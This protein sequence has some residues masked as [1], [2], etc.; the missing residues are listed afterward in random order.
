MSITYKFSA[1]WDQ[2]GYY[3][4]EAHPGDPLNHVTTPLTWTDWAVTASAG[5]SASQGSADFAYGVLFTDWT[6]GTTTTAFVQHG[7]A[8]DSIAADIDNSAPY[9]LIFWVKSNSASYDGIALEVSVYNTS[10]VL[11]ATSSAFTVTDAEGWKKIALSFTTLPTGSGLFF[12]LGKVSSATSVR[13]WVAGLMMVDG[14][15]TASS[16]PDFNVGHPS[17]AYDN[18]LP[19]VIDAQWNVGARRAYVDVAETNVL[20]LTLDNTSKTF[21]P[22]NASSGLNGL[23]ADRYLSVRA[24]SALSIERTVFFGYVQAVQ[25]LPGTTGPYTAVLTA[26]SSRRYWEGKQVR[27][28]LQTSKRADEVIAALEA[29]ITRP[30]SPLV[31]NFVDTGTYTWAYAGDNWED[32]VDALSALE[33]VV[34]AERGFFYWS[35]DDALTFKNRT[36]RY[37]FDDQVTTISATFTDT[38]AEMD[39]DYGLDV[40]NDVEVTYYPRKV[41]AST[42]A[43]LWELQESISIPPSS[44]ET[45]FTRYTNGDQDATVGAVPGTVAVGTFTTSGGTI[46]YSLSAKAQGCIITLSNPSASV[47]RTVTAMTLTGQRIS[48]FNKITVSRQDAASID[49]YGQHTTQL[50]LRLVN[51][52][53]DANQI[54]QLELDRFKNPKGHVR[55]ITI[56][57]RD[58]TFEQYM[59]DLRVGLK[60]R[61]IESQTAHDGSY[62]IVGEW[63]EVTNA[64]QT[65]RVTY[66]L[67]PAIAVI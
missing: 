10:N 40:M 63:H 45:I 28:S 61:V 62:M 22:E 56:S 53:A 16:A 60:I 42:T 51:A 11:I 15:Y 41:G 37:D 36:A 38:Q 31:V 57:Q 59:V 35:R 64:L 27:I 50:D 58:A 39:Y 34:R 54:T 13:F 66:Y 32:G 9:T 20:T 52:R 49:Q 55:R 12:R 30:P 2:D 19:F 6:S 33:A 44:S 47:T 4:T 7:G 67:E 1:D 17:N 26:T 14:T 21:S 43:L 48:A 29:E 65:H 3:C 24:Q 18:L 25:P 46:N 5:G 8:L 23:M